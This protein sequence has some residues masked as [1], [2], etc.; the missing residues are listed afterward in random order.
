MPQEEVIKCKIYRAEDGNNHEPQWERPGFKKDEIETR[1]KDVVMFRNNYLPNCYKLF[2]EVTYELPKKGR[3]EPLGISNRHGLV[4]RVNYASPFKGAILPGDVLLSVNGTNVCFEE[5][6]IMGQVED[7][8]TS[9]QTSKQKNPEK[10]GTGKEGDKKDTKPAFWAGAQEFKSVVS[11]ILASKKETKITITVARLKT[12]VGTFKCPPGIT[13]TPGYNLDL[14]LLYQFKYLK[15]G[16]NMQQTGQRVVVN[17]TMPDSVSHISLNIGEAILAV[18]ESVVTNL[19]DVRTR[20]LD[21]CKENGWVRLIVE[22]PNTDQFKNMVRG[23]LATAQ[24][25]NDR[26]N[27]SLCGDVKKYCE[28]GVEALKNGKELDPVLKE[29]TKESDRKEPEKKKKESLV[30]FRKTTDE[31]GIPTEWNSKLFVL[32][33]PLKTKDSES[34]DNSQ[35]KK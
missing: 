2:V 18:D 7:K 29:P 23:Q 10:K 14:A 15:L 33:P 27:Y 31:I 9:Q 1:V 17:Y 4:T 5:K 16:L 26:P 28:E 3:N 21:G 30:E 20:I 13:P 22:Y 32:L 35:M 34:T 8:T 19:E 12:R 11:K 24:K 25:T 6:T